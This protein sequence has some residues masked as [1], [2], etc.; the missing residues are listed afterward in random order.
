MHAQIAEA[1][2]KVSFYPTLHSSQQSP[3][4]L[5]PLFGRPIFTRTTFF[6]DQYSLGPLFMAKMITMRTL[7]ILSLQSE[8]SWAREKEDDDDHG[9]R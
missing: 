9:G 8:H 1:G 5:G 2:R 6:R 7:I 3:C 4:Y